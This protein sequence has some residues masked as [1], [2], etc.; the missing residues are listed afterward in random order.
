MWRT[1]YVAVTLELFFQLI[2][3]ST[4]PYLPGQRGVGDTEGR[5][6]KA[7]KS[8]VEP[9]LILRKRGK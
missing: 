9:M 1:P 5:G 3:Q 6:L 4:D 7:K 8:P 2:P